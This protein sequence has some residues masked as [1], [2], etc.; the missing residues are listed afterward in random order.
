M[1][2]RKI[3]V[4]FLAVGALMSL[5]RGET[6]RERWQKRR[7]GG[8]SATASDPLKSLE[9]G[10][11]ERT[12][13]LHL[14]PGYD[15]R[16][17]YP[18][19]LLFHGGGGGAEQALT[20]YPLGEVADREG[21]ILVAP[22]GTGRFEK[23][24]LRTWNVKFG[25]G[26]ALAENVDDVAFVDD[27]L[28]HLTAEYSIDE[29]RVY[30]TGLSNGAILCHFL[31][32]ALGDRIAAIA[33]VVG[34]AGGRK[35]D[36]AGLQTPGTP[37]RPVSVILFNG[38]KDDHIPLEGGWQRKSVQEAAFI[39][40]AE[41]SARFWVNANGCRPDPVVEKFPDKKHR[42]YTWTGGKNGTE[43]TLYVLEDQGHAWPGGAT[44]RWGSDPPSTNV[45][46]HEVMWEF[47][48]RHPRR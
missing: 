43:V 27:L 13:R 30:L 24:L 32:A 44:P 2:V 48:E 35:K 20:H 4:A 31:A 28:D 39:L 11:R 17:K 23:D 5:A 40:S 8:G 37:V 26:L 25:F 7:T 16:K 12:F 9:S 34:T 10:G 15:A 18:L 3:T 45:K 33:P 36:Q 1:N 42:R 22:S 6:W 19:V 21:F 46:A 14:P 47:F 38:E 29:D 41:E